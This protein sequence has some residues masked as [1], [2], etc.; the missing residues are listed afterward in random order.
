MSRMSAAPSDE[1]YGDF[2]TGIFSGL[3][4]QHYAA[5][6]KMATGSIRDGFSLAVQPL[7]CGADQQ[8]HVQTRF[9]LPTRVS[10]PKGPF[11][12]I[13]GYSGVAKNHLPFGYG[14]S[15][16]HYRSSRI[17]DARF[18]GGER[19]SR[20]AAGTTSG[21][22]LVLWGRL[23]PSTVFLKCKTGCRNQPLRS[24]PSLA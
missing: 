13:C 22:G 21:C 6:A 11:S 5:V 3:Q 16:S 8:K 10:R 24:K 14:R 17:S 19:H 15:D 9:C 12:P 2:A 1:R 4:L 18:E 7:P 23:P 20:N